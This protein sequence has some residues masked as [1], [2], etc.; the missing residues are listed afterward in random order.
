MPLARG[1]KAPGPP[2]PPGLCPARQEDAARCSPMQKTIPACG[3]VLFWE[4]EDIGMMGIWNLGKSMP[5]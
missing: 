4:H 3:T 5:M 2:V 1:W